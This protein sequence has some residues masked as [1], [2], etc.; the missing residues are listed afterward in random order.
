MSRSVK[1]KRAAFKALHQQGCFIIPNPYD[2]G[3]ARMLEIGEWVS[4]VAE[5]VGGVIQAGLVKLFG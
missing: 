1:D 2:V 3:T 5:G 4:I